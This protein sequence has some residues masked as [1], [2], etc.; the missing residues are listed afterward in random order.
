MNQ[1]FICPH[2]IAEQLISNA[3]EC[4]FCDKWPT[5]ASKAQ[6]VRRKAQEEQP[7]SSKKVHWVHSRTLP[8]FKGRMH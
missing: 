7:S 4:D 5:C 6:E 2:K 8:F 3:P 1:E